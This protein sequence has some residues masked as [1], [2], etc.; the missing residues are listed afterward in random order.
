MLCSLAPTRGAGLSARTWNTAPAV[1]TLAPAHQWATKALARTGVSDRLGHRVQPLRSRA[2]RA[3]P[4]VQISVGDL[5]RITL[6]VTPQNTAG[7]SMMQAPLTR[8]P[9][10]G[11]CWRRLMLVYPVPQQDCNRRQ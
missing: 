2:N 8:V 1:S 3:S 9:R 11:F 10:C 7:S 6:A 5:D 4:M